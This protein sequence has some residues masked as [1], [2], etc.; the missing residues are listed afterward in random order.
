MPNDV[1]NTPSLCYGNIEQT[2]ICLLR[3]AIV[4]KC[5]CFSISSGNEFGLLWN[6]PSLALELKT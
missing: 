2:Y 1:E 3:T 4:D 5:F 6:Y